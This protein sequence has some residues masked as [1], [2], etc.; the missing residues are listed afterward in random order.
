MDK[1]E[2]QVRCLCEQGDIGLWDQPL[3]EEDQKKY[4]EQE[5]KDNK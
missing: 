5:K 3:S 1:Q 2:E 4:Q